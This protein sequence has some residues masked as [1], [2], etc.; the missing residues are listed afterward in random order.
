MSERHSRTYLDSRS[1]NLVCHT[2]M[3]LGETYEDIR[4]HGR[5]LHGIW[6]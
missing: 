4:L 2:T 3:A 6:Y 5:Y 1:G